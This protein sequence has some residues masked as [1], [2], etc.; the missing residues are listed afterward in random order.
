MKPK[1]SKI[2]NGV[3]FAPTIVTNVHDEMTVVKEEI[4]GPVMCILP[5]DDEEEGIKRANNT[6][7]GLCAGV[8]TK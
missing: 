3:Y 1:D 7:F 6:P 8:F 5:F 2:A 4:F